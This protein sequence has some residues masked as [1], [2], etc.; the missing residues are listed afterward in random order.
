M[1]KWSISSATRGST[2]IWAGTWPDSRFSTQSSDWT[3]SNEE[4][5]LLKGT[6]D[7]TVAHIL[8]RTTNGKRENADGI[9]ARPRRSDLVMIV[10]QDE[11]LL[12]SLTGTLRRYGFHGNC[13]IEL[14]RGP[15]D[16]FGVQA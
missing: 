7:D 10:D 14:R 13:G 8:K 5:K 3:P 2:S 1:R 15:R 11:R 12:T 6:I 9:Q 4:G 16:F